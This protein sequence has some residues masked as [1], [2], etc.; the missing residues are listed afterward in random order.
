MIF[1]DPKNPRAVD[2]EQRLRGVFAGEEVDGLHLV[3]GGDGFLLRTVSKHGL[4]RPYLGLSCG[5]LGFLMN[6]V[7][8]SVERLARLLTERRWRVMR[9]PLLQADLRC[10][11]GTHTQES[12]INDVGLFR[13]GAHACK[14][15]ITVDDQVVVERMAGDGLLV[16]TALGSTGYSFSAG[17][18]PHH[19]EVP[20]LLMTPVCPHRPKLSPVALPMTAQIEVDVLNPD[21]R[22]VNAMADGRSVS[23]VVGMRVGYGEAA[24]E[25]AYLEG[26]DYT[27]HLVEKIL[28]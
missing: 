14:L 10:A 20:T 8:D 28:R 19:P 13:A 15:R 4:H 27:R 6:E 16:A 18:T 24:V 9:H 1:A 17:G 11:D 2:L 22:P 21:R 25:L 12:A 3:L 26:H 23:D 5:T 7:P